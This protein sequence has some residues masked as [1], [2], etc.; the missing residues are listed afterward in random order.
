MTRR[1]WLL[2]VLLAA[3][4]GASYMFIKVGLDDGLDPVFV[5]FS[6]I[7]LGALVLV[8][9]ALRA[10]AFAPLRGRWGAI[11]VIA[12]VQVVVPFLLITF[13]QERIAS[14]LAGILVSAAPIFTALIAIRV[15]QE[16]RARGIA[17]AG[18]VVGIVGVVL[19]FG[20][21]LSGDASALAGGLM[22]LLAALGYAVGVLYLKH[23]L[24]GVPPVG[25]AAAT[26]VLGTL[27]LLPAVPFALPDAAPSLEA[28]GSLL[29]LGAGGT[30]IAFLIFYTLIA[31]I[32]PGRASIVAYI[33]PGFAVGY[34]VALLGEPLTAGGVLGLG[35][36]LGGS[37]LAAEG[38]LPWQPRVVP[39]APLEPPPV[40]SEPV[41]L[42]A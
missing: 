25:I 22:V 3:L 2:M 34:G 26:M 33:A 31:A 28:T 19:L 14:S 37:W 10:G 16:E 6:R 15:D 36:I 17:G 30:G 38:R 11:A 12:V 35:L 13:G 32:G 39:V 1:A 27:V 40:P 5:V 23:R 7:V 24:S 29:A 8:P 18:I 42:P 41:R 4:W 21:D 20:V 9:I